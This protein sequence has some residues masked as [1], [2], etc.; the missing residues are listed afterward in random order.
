MLS[1]AIQS[2]TVSSII[3]LYAYKTSK[4][5]PAGCAAVFVAGTTAGV[6]GQYFGERSAELDAAAAAAAAAAQQQ[7][8]Q[9]KTDQ[10]NT[11]ER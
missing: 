3:S 2:V 10:D 5:T 7:Q 9:Q 8:Q 11:P 4:L 1:T 6:A